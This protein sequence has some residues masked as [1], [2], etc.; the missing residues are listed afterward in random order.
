VAYFKQT[1]QRAMDYP[2]DVSRT[3][4]DHLH[5]LNQLEILSQDLQEG[6]IDPHSEEME[7]LRLQ[8]QA[9]ENTEQIILREGIS[10]DYP[11]S[12]NIIPD[13]NMTYL[14]GFV[15]CGHV[16]E[17]YCL[18]P[19]QIREIYGVDIESNFNAYHENELE[20]IGETRNTDQ[21]GRTTARVWEI[22]D[23]NDGLVYTVCDGY[24]DYLTE[25]HEPVTYSERFYPWFVYAPNAVDDPDDPFPPS[26]VELMMPMQ[27]EIN[28]AG[29][30]LRQHRYAA[31]PSWV[32]GSAIAESDLKKMEARKAHS[33]IV[34]KSLEP[35]ADIRA[36]LQA[37]PTPPIDPNLY[38]TGP[39][40]A[41]ILR[42]VGTQEANLGGTSNATATETSIAESSRQSTLGSAIDEFDDLLTEMARA[43]GQLLLTEMN[44]QKVKE[45]VGPG[46]IWPEQTREEVAKEVY[47]EVEAG[48]SGRPNQAQEVAIMERVYPL[49]F[50]IPG[51][52]HEE[53]ARHGVRVLD[54]S[55]S[56]EDWVDMNALSIMAV[57][58]QQQAAANRGGT[59]PGDNGQGGG[60]NAARPAERGGE[61]PTGPGQQGM[62]MTQTPPGAQPM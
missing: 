24:H 28:R 33:L 45:I 47:L 39:Q 36:K 48:S 26:D 21:K 10:L 46:A 23:Q 42:S 2:P 20:P 59:M 37:F 29:E 6:D 30:A 58:G 49:L 44:A 51:L 32:S 1:F 12:V 25:P 60:D 54:D 55:A 16:T 43:G 19:E 50:Q 34:L 38:Q 5:R 40:F 62:G 22:W 52:S 8:L 61:G 27:A 9:L 57:N 7:N 15:G 4:N 41:D 31:R 53:L 11:D 13:K 14:P 35:D 56:Y 17:Q 18:T 3:I